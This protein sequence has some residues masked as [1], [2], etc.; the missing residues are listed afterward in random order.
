MNCLGSGSIEGIKKWEGV[1]QGDGPAETVFRVILESV[2]LF[3]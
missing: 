1:Q 2:K 3:L